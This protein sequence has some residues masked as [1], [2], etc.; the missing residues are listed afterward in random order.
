MASSGLLR[1]AG[2]ATRSRHTLFLRQHP[3]VPATIAAPSRLVASSTAC[4]VPSK[5]PNPAPGAEPLPEDAPRQTPPR[6][7]EADPVGPPTPTP[8]EKITGTPPS[9]E[10]GGLPG[11]V[12][13]TTPPPDLPLPPVSPPDDGRIVSDG[14]LRSSLPS[15][16]LP[17]P[18]TTDGIDITRYIK[19]KL[20]AEEETDTHLADAEWRAIDVDIVLWIYTTISDE[21]QDV[22][23]QADSTAYTAWQAFPSSPR[24]PPAL[25]DVGA[26][27]TDKKLTMRLIDGLA[28]RF[29]TQGE[30]L[31][32]G[33]TFPTFMH[34]QSRLQLAEQKLKSD[35]A[36]PPQVMHANGGTGGNGAPS[37]CFNGTCYACAE[38][39][40]MARNF[41]RGDRGGGY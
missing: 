30:L 11:G 5:V 6:L 18:P 25:S 20:N 2:G 27:V 14:R 39:G 22:I 4:N 23:L 41:T 19:F 3:A 7:G 40:H 35:E 33:T 13:D 17:S 32:G 15:Y 9:E 34:A 38:P 31:E 12:P 24:T 36:E 37:Y 29:R 10:D 26:P 21:I 8:K 28:K 16:H 1:A